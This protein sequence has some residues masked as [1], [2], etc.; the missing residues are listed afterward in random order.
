MHV[1]LWTILLFCITVGHIW[2]NRFE[3]IHFMCSVYVHGSK[4]SIKIKRTRVCLPALC[5]EFFHLFRWENALILK[6]WNGFFFTS[7]FSFYHRT[8]GKKPFFTFFFLLFLL[9][10]F[11]FTFFLLLIPASFSEKNFD[12]LPVDDKMWTWKVLDSCNWKFLTFTNI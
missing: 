6:P 8:T 4:S 11:F 9:I 12:R 7:F 10:S 5:L 2:T 3:S 1:Q